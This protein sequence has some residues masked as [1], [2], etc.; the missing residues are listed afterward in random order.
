MKFFPYLL[1]ICIAIFSCKKKDC[2]PSGV[3]QDDSFVFGTKCY[4]DSV[5][6]GFGGTKFF[7]DCDLKEDGKISLNKGC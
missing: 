2:I 3:C 1:I 6:N 4:V 5:C 7:N